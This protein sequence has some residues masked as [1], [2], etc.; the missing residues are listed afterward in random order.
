ML[1]VT[2]IYTVINTQ[3]THVQIPLRRH[4]YNWKQNGKNIEISLRPD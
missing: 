1:E 2:N 3:A 4:L